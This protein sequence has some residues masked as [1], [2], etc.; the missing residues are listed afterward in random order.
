MRFQ[1]VNQVLAGVA[2]SDL[3]VLATFVPQFVAKLD[4]VKHKFP[5]YPAV[6]WIIHE[7]F[8]A[9]QNSEL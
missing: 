9:V 8:L 3:I 4:S 2:L 1:V 5:Y 7:Y 6:A